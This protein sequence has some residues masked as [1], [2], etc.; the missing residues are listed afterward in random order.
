[1]KTLSVAATFLAVALT[2]VLG[3][4]GGADTAQS[5]SKSQSAETL[6]GQAKRS[7]PV[8]SPNGKHPT[9]NAGF[10]HGNGSLWVA[11]WP[12]GKLVAGTFPD[13]SSRAEIRSDGSIDA[14]LGW[15]RGV[16]GE[17]DHRRSATRCPRAATPGRYP[18]RLRRFRVSGDW[19]HFPNRRMLASD[20]ESRGSGTQFRDSRGQ[21]KAL[22]PPPPSRK[23]P[24]SFFLGSFRKRLAR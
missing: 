1:M 7:C 10:N 15:W 20:R 3:C 6:S 13:G 21:T 8:T 11:L 14:K 18:A 9:K 4:S 12:H 17:F 24:R 2:T 5:R 23:R 22:S 16:E 19:D